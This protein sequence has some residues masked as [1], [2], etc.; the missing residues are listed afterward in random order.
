MN[1]SIQFPNVLNQGRFMT[2]IISHDH[3]VEKTRKFAF[4]DNTYVVR[5]NQ[6]LIIFL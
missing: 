5:K 6:S 1:I 4:H 2:Y 3:C